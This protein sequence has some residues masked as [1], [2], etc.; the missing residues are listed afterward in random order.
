MY[1][2]FVKFTPFIDF[3]IAISIKEYSKNLLSPCCCAKKH[4]YEFIVLKRH[5]MSAHKKF[6][7]GG[8]KG[9]VT[10]I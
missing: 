7:F 8:L 2:K 3:F 5:L 4:T 10:L 1:T 9:I 6:T